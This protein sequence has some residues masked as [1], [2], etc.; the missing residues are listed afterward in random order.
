[1]KRLTEED[2]KYRYIS[3]ALE[4]AGW[5]KEQ[6]FM[7][8]FF[9]EGQVLVSGNRV[10]RG[11]RK[12][13]DYLLIRK[14]G[15]RP[16]AIVE[17]KDADHSVGD[18]MQQAMNCAEILNIPFTYSSNGSGFI[19]YDYFTGAETELSIDQFPSENK[20][21]RRYL[22]NSNTNSNRGGRPTQLTK[23]L[24][25]GIPLLLKGGRKKTSAD[26]VYRIHKSEIL[27][28]F[29]IFFPADL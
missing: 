2:I 10:K 18:G 29:S 23:C 19:E 21:W 20:L 12:K 27:R 26:S 15:H 17:A 14:E 9:T 5:I 11:K 1:M 4:S 3:P 16:L 6:V 28:I 24:T 13:A 22:I 25:L 8:Y 7:E